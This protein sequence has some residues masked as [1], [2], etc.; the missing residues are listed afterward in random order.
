MLS[1]RIYVAGYGDGD[2]DDVLLNSFQSLTLPLTLNHSVIGRP[3]L[4]M[5][6]VEIIALNTK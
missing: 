1:V 2:V 4:S 5:T 6:G 3:I